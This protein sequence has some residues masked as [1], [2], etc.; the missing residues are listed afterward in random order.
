[1]EQ[2]KLLD[3]VALLD[4]I[5][6]PAMKMEMDRIR[7][8]LPETTA[9]PGLHNEYIVLDFVPADGRLL[10]TTDGDYPSVRDAAFSEVISLPAGETVVHALRIGDNGLVSPLT[11]VSFTIGGVIE[12]AR[13][14]DAAIE[15]ALREMLKIDP[16]DPVMT[17]RLWEVSE[18]TVPEEA[19]S[20]ADLAYLPYLAK[21][22]VTDRSLTSLEPLASLQKL[23]ELDLSGCR[24]SAAELEVLTKLPQLQK[25][26]LSDCG[27]SSIN[28]LTGANRLVWLD[29]SG[30]TLRNLASLSEMVFLQELYLQHNAVT[31]LDALSTLKSLNKLDLSYNSVQDLTPLTQCLKLTW[32]N[33]GNNQIAALDGLDQLTGLTSLYLNRNKLTNVN[34][35]QALTELTTLNLS[36]NEITDID[37]LAALVNLVELHCS[38]NKLTRLP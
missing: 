14:T 15:L 12:E 16:E 25:L 22:T 2:D 38:N 30:N 33:A 24:F 35:L 13:F 32:L 3:A 36:D 6:N 17:D 10:C 26:N 21:L 9:A 28:A 11:L 23:S 19:N 1:V 5:D 27:L 7:P 37:S 8:A 34:V 20:L 4:N 31:G 18:F 29:L